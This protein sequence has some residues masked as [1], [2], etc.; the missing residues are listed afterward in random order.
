MESSFYTPEELKKLKFKAIGKDVL[1]S[2]CARIY[3]MKSIE[4]GS[5]VRIDD[6]C[7]QRQD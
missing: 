4:I 7:F 5:N 3:D 2:R 6:F 1:I